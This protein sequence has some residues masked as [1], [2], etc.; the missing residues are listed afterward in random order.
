MSHCETS[1]QSRDTNASDGGA[2]RRAGASLSRRREQPSS[3]SDSRPRRYC[4]SVH[5][6]SVCFEYSHV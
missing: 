6:V 4:H 2:R 1:K 5:M 3:G